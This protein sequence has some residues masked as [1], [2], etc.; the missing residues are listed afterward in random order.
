MSD[1]R[2]EAIVVGF[3]YYGRFL[4]ALVNERS[5]RWHLTYYG[6]GKFDALRGIL[7]ARSADAIVTF[8]GP[9]P[10]VA[11]VDI[12]RR[13]K[14]PVIVIWAGSDVASSQR[15][16]GLLEVIKRYAFTNVADGPWLVDELAAL[17]IA[18]E[19]VPVTAIEAPE[20]LTPFPQKFS[21]LTY[22]PE[23]R[24]AFYGERAVYALAREFPDIPFRVVGRGARNPIAPKNVEF[25]GYVDDMP[26]RI[27]DATVV[28]R[29]P[30]HDGKSMLVLEALARGRHV[31][32]NYDFPGVHHAPRTVDAAAILRELC[33]ANDNG[34]LELNREGSAFVAKRFNRNVLAAGFEATLERAVETRSHAVRPVRKR[35]AIG[36]LNLFTAQIA[37]ELE[38]QP[39]AWEPVILR[40]RS[41]LEV[42]SSLFTL[43]SAHVWYSIGAPLGDRWLY[44]WWQFV[45]TPRVIHWVGSDI[46]MLSSNARLR[47]LCRQPHVVNLAEADWT[48]EE[49]RRFG[50]D[51]AFAPLPPRLAEPKVTPLPE[52]F[53]VLLYIPKTRGDFYGR[54]EYE[55]LMRAFVKRDVKFIV[56]GG[57]ECYV[58]PGADVERVGWAASLDPIYAR[59]TVLIRFT[60]HD[61][62]SLMALEALACGRHLLWSQPFPYGVTIRHYDEIE[63]VIGNLLEKHERGELE[64]QYDAAHYVGEIYNAKRC[65]DRIVHYLDSALVAA[66]GAPA[67]VQAQS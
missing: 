31:I 66:D 11:L 65:V 48:I 37:A 22:L 16:P 14:I 6:A 53:T 63:R 60:K 34:T 4:S 15:D 3:D 5:E 49:L 45:R 24:R 54:R 10:N 19:Y 38:T 47:A 43:A 35:V 13:R 28:L 51:A 64:P 27:D 32:W 21:V 39:T 67:A 30:E 12:A 55:R 58:P 52:K 26:R 20:A 18:A 9:S 1:K 46:A 23:P 40:M 59:T 33:A 57:G 50:I 36:G 44:L 62:L 7:A 42:F 41:R 17:G 61:G 2:K 8:G 56:V 25:L 29:L